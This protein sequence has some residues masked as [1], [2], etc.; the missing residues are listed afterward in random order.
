[1]FLACVEKQIILKNIKLK[2]P[3]LILMLRN[4]QYSPLLPVGRKCKNILEEILQFNRKYK[5][6]RME[7]KQSMV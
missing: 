2:I 4:R 7:L 3:K 6:E 1:M 5:Y